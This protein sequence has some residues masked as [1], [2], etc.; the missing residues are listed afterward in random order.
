M[1]RYRST[2]QTAEVNAAVFCDFDD[3]AFLSASLAP[4]SLGS[5]ICLVTGESALLPSLPS[6]RRIPIVDLGLDREPVDAAD[7]LEKLRLLLASVE[8]LSGVIVDMG[9]GL[10]AVHSA[11]SYETWGG[12]ADRLASEIGVPILS[13]YN[14][15]QMIEEQVQA[16]FRAHRQFLA[17]SGLYENPF[18]IPEAMLHDASLD[19]KLEFMLGRVV[20]DYAG[21]TP[22]S[23][24]ERQ[25]ARG[26]SPDWLGRAPGPGAP[27]GKGMRW[28]IQCLGRLTVHTGGPA[29][30]D[31]TTAG[32]APNKTRT[33]FAYLLHAGAKGVPAERIGELLWP[34]GA[35]EKTKR[36]R[37]HH[38]VAMLRR[39]LGG[40]DTVIRSGDY[41]RLNVPMGS[42]LDITA[43]EQLCRRA[44]SLAR[45]GQT[46][47]A[48]P[49][50]YTAERLYRGDLFEDLP[51]EYVQPEHEDWVMPRR[52]W[53]REMAMRVQYDMSAVLR[54]EGRASEALEHVQRALAFDPTNEAANIEALRVFFAQGRIPAMHRHFKQF[55]SAIAALG[56]DIGGG[57]I[58]EVYAELCQAVKELS[59]DQR[60]TKVLGL[61]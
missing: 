55:R 9:W 45:H 20:P 52:T 51:L 22:F 39:V 61:R 28:H 53:L 44:F 11:S 56:E 14:K 15:A 37:L 35:A 17:P 29:P 16:A 54:A 36:A 42:S 7:V 26:A 13:V 21:T 30:V 12:I 27:A 43:F 38:T 18:W 50:Y 25:A 34:E 33:L 23:K 31:W 32:G 19:E 48:L 60:K 3:T 41:Y 49:L 1:E 5:G 8:G 10:T 46:A 57:E 47:A 4:F 59:P 40:Q 58:D 2:T 24:I 6:A